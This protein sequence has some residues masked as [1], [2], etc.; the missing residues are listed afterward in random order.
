[1]ANLY[2]FHDWVEINVS[3]SV[4]KNAVNNKDDVIVV[5]AMLKYAL[6]WRTYFGSAPFPRPTGAVD[7]AT[8]ALIRKYQQ[9]L[10]RTRGSKISVDGRIDPAKDRAAFGKKG[11]WTIQMLNGDV[12]EGWLVW[13]R[14]GDN[15]IHS[16]YMEY[17][18]IRN[19]I[20]DNIPVGKLGLSLEPSNRPVGTL[21]LGLE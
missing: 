2:R 7:S 3:A 10:R 17:P 18:E 5:Q 16:L 4:G 15:P 9:Y 19:A 12:A 14:P 8:L 21:N 13:D 1:M 6:E 20:G 11:Q